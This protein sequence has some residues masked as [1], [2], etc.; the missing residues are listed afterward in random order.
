LLERAKA[1]EIVLRLVNKGFRIA[2]RLRRFFSIIRFKVSS[3]YLYCG[4]KRYV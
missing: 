4:L 3:I 2:V 1:K